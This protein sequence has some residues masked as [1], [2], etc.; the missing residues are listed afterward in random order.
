MPLID[1]DDGHRVSVIGFGFGFC[2]VDIHVNFFQHSAVVCLSSVLCAYDKFFTDL[3]QLLCIR[4][5]QQCIRD[6]FTNIIGNY[7]NT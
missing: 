4:C 5:K 1:A 7:K 6:I 2:G 3:F